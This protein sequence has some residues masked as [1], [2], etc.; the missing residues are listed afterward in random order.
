V[1]NQSRIVVLLFSTPYLKE[2]QNKRKTCCKF[3]STLSLSFSLSSFAID[4]LRI[5][6]PSSQWNIAMFFPWIL[7]LLLREH[8]QILTNDLTSFAWFNDIIN[9]TFVEKE[10]EEERG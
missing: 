2:Q 4:H 1:S 6:H 8:L 5:S 10:R 7:K 9:K 3:I